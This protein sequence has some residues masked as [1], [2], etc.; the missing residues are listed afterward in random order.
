MALANSD[1][2][3]LIAE[4]LNMDSMLSFML[5]SRTNYQ[6]ARRCERSIVK[7]KMARTVRDPVLKPP[8]GTLL[9]SSP[10][11]PAQPSSMDREVLDPWSFAVAKE[12]ESRERRISA[13][14]SPRSASPR[15]GETLLDGL[16]QLPPY[17]H[18]RPDQ[19]E[20][21]VE[22]LKDACRVADRIADCAASVRLPDQHTP[23]PKKTGGGPGGRDDDEKRW[24]V[25]HKV[26][27]AR[28]E[29]VRSL[30]PIRLAFLTLLRRLAGAQY[31]LRQQ[32]E[33]WEPY[34]ETFWERVT[35]LEETF[36]R[37]GTAVISALLS[38]SEPADE[39]HR[40]RQEALE[41]GVG[42]S[43]PPHPSASA[44]YF[45]SQVDMVLREVLAYEGVHVVV[46]SPPDE[47]EEGEG[48]EAHARPIPDSLHMTVLHAFQAPEEESDEEAADR[49]LETADEKEDAEGGWPLDIDVNVLD[50]DSDGAAEDEP[51]VELWKP[52]PRDALILRWVKGKYVEQTKPLG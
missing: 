39:A 35:A 12:L 14:F 23:P 40:A 8:L 15:G 7:A 50:P 44:E 5:S 31:T 9:S 46:S 11:P 29:F 34:S 47:L 20:R 27:L 21:L 3:V 17:Q 13:I 37:H 38:P 28:Q 49:G 25:S 22:G 6:L 16:R 32:Q 48:E 43:P 19:T 2:T 18:L 41:F 1:V 36:L 42:H 52:D 51:P 26:H 33:V 30:S 24:A 10:P 4:H 45:A